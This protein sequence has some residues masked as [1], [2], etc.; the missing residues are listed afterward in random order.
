MQD[1]NDPEKQ[2]NS[3]QLLRQS[4]KQRRELWMY[5]AVSIIAI[6][7]F[8]FVAALFFAFIASGNGPLK[9][10]WLSWAAL[11]VGIPAVLLVAV[12]L[13]VGLFTGSSQQDEEWQRHL[14][15]RLQKTY[16]FIKRAPAVVLLLGLIAIGAALFTLDG[17]LQLLENF[18]VLFKP[19][20]LH[21]LIGVGIVIVLLGMGAFWFNYRTRKLYAEY[22]YR[23]TVFEKT[24]L[25][26]VDKDRFIL[27]GD[28]A[29]LTPIPVE[30]VKALPQAKVDEP[31]SEQEPSPHTLS[32]A[33]Q[34]TPSASSSSAEGDSPLS[35]ADGD[36]TDANYTEVSPDEKK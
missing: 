20:I 30:S 27:S 17:A 1:N 18:L 19:Y 36:I 24:G 26:I 23:K 31:K 8:L 15:E 5:L 34:G 25:I 11:S 21:I 6:E 28:Q 22:E 7:L 12:H 10:P 32:D 35:D 2:K 16:T 3:E 29:A 4:D 33:P 9:F 14:P 13:A